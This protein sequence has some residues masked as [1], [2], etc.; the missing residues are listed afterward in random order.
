MLVMSPRVGTGSGR[1]PG[2]ARCSV[3][4]AF[5][6]GP[7]V[8]YLCTFIEL[9]S[10]RGGS[11]GAAAV[12]A[13]TKQQQVPTNGTSHE[14]LKEPTWSETTCPHLCEHAHT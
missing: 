12:V 2:I 4:L 11:S 1:L 14:G 10:S 3:H 9:Q 7:A 6:A 5:A 8:G 13:V